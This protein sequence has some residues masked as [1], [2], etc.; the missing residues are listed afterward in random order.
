MVEKPGQ[1][2]IPNLNQKI[3]FKKSLFCNKK[4]LNL[5]TLQIKSSKNIMQVSQNIKSHNQI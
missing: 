3:F 4:N 2:Q 5:K 1:F